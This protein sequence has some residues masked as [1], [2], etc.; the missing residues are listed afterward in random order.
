M[1]LR[2]IRLCSAE[3][4]CTTP[5]SRTRAARR[6]TTRVSRRTARP[7]TGRCFFFL[8]SFLL[9]CFVYLVMYS[10]L[11]PNTHSCCLFIPFFCASLPDGVH[12]G[13]ITLASLSI[14]TCLALP[15]L[16]NSHSFSLVSSFLP[17]PQLERE[18]VS[19]RH[20]LAHRVLHC[21]PALRRLRLWR[22]LGPQFQPGSLRGNDVY[23]RGGKYGLIRLIC[24]SLCFF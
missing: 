15:L 22:R 13:A 17:Q 21:T 3:T 19:P 23:G 24:N 8:F 18:R 5:T 11:L 9:F 16:L 6:Q 10:P 14:I 12:G 2:V 20:V 1:C 7:G 4:R